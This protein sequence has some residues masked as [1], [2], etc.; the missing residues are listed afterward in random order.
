MSA[1]EAWTKSLPF[2]LGILCFSCSSAGLGS[3]LFYEGVEL[4]LVLGHD[5]ELAGVVV[6][7][8]AKRVGDGVIVD[9]LGPRI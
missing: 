9:H 5:A 3:W 8:G 6:I 4:A 2:I 7:A 1:L